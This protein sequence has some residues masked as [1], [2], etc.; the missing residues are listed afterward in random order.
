MAIED[1]VPGRL[2]RWVSAAEPDWDAIYAEQLPRVYNFFHVRIGDRPEVEDLTSVTFEK[3]PA[4]QAPV[5]P[6]YRRLHDL[7]AD[8]RPQ[9]GHRLL[10]RVTV[11]VRKSNRCRAASRRRMTQHGGRDG[12]TERAAGNAAGSGS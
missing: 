11:P 4:C 5:P 6:G 2:A 3:A 10:S 12:A 9:R 8:H 1:T 7:A